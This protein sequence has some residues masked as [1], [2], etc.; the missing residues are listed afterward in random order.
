MAKNRNRNAALPPPT[1]P[2]PGN[3]DLTS[4]GWIATPG[5]TCFSAIRV[6][7]T[8]TA[9][10]VT[11]IV[12]FRQ[13]GREYPYYGVPQETVLDLLSSPSR[14]RYY[15]HQIKGTFRSGVGR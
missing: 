9:S 4:I 1:G 3:N 11:L 7:G 6:V 12:R 13:S 14:G 8:P 5:S 2:E 15:N 10:A